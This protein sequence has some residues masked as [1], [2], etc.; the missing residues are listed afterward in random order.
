MLE[1]EILGAEDGAALERAAMTAALAAGAIDGHVA[2]AIVDEDE[3]RRLN[4]EHR[5]RDSATDVLSFPVDG[6]GPAS[7]PRELGDVVICPSTR[8]TRARS[9]STACCTSA[10]TTTRPTTARCSPCRKS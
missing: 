9:W 6:E 4:R 7:G 1:V 8:P 10:A 3:I 5:D 2:V